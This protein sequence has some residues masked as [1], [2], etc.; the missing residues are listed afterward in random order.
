MA[1][2]TGTSRLAAIVI[3]EY[4]SLS[5]SSGKLSPGGI[6]CADIEHAIPDEGST[7][8]LGELDVRWCA[9]Q[10]GV[11]ESESG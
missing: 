8:R 5:T 3:T 7:P 11:L 1:I 4:H 9:T 2:V 10:R 6:A